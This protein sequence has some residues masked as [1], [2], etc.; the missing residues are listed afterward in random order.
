MTHL[1][2]KEE[3]SEVFQQ[4]RQ[5]GGELQEDSFDGSG[6]HV[7]LVVQEI[8]CSAAF[9][10]KTASGRKWGGGDLEGK[11]VSEDFNQEGKVGLDW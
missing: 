2:F 7:W 10:P 9:R 5:A 3:L 11:K 6:R 4:A 8:E 1:Q